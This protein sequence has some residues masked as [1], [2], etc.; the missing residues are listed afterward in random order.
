MG[1]QQQLSTAYYPQ[2]DGQTE[3]VNQCLETYLR[4]MCGQ[5]PKSWGVLIPLAEWWYN[6]SYHTTIKRSPFEALYGFPPP[7]LGYGP[8]LIPKSAGVEVWV[9]DKQNVTQHLKKLLGEAR[10]RM[11]MQADKGRSERRFQIGDQVYL[12][13][14]PYRQLSMRKSRVWKLAPKYCGPFP[15][16]KKVG[17]VAYELALPSDARIHPVLHV[18]QLKKYIGNADKVVSTLPPMDPQG[19]FI[20]LPVAVL[21]TRIVKKKN[22]AAGQWLIQWAYSPLLTA[23]IFVMSSLFLSGIITDVTT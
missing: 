2:T 23:P 6:S 20:L 11:K 1:I 10:E 14:K 8:H 22:V 19:Q 4:C 7:Q 15:I 18:S 3:R 21:D 12:K 13:L 9:K 5:I 16:I 17:E